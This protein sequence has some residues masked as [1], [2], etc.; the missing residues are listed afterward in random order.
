M[1]RARQA[2]PSQA[3]VRVTIMLPGGKCPRSA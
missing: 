2:M 3:L 1:Q